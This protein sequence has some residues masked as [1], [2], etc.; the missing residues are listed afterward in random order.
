MPVAWPKRRPVRAAQKKNLLI[1]YDHHI[2]ANNEGLQ[3][4][5]QRFLSFLAFGKKPPVWTS[6]NVL[7]KLLQELT[8]V[9]KKIQIPL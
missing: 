5:G 8:N 4:T 7:Q 3:G 2:W 9:K 6:T 1:L